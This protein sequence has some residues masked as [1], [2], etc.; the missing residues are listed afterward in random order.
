M[1]FLSNDPPDESWEGWRKRS[2]LHNTAVLFDLSAAELPQAFPPSSLRWPNAQ[3]MPS[4]RLEHPSPLDAQ[5]QHRRSCATL[6]ILVPAW[7]LQ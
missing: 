4:A 1:A 6:E 3:R 7:L 2:G 5:E